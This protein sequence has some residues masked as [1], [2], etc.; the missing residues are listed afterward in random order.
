M[1]KRGRRCH[2]VRRIPKDIQHIDTRELIQI[3]LKTDSLSLAQQRAATLD[4]HILEYWQ[5]LITTPDKAH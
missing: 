4:K 3:S 5:N 2:Y 1:K